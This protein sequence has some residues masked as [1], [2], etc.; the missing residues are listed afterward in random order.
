MISSNGVRMAVKA[1]HVKLVHVRVHFSETCLLHSLFMEKIFN[2]AI[3]GLFFFTFV[4]SIL[5]LRV[6]IKFADN[7]IV[8]GDFWYQN[9]TV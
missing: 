5:Q 2:W 8:T 4:F 3:L 9:V 6:N 1:F 7:W